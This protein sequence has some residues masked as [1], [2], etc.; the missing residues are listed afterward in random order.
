MPDGTSEWGG[1]PVAYS[2][3]DVVPRCRTALS[4]AI[5]SVSTHRG[6]SERLL[7]SGGGVWMDALLDDGTGVLLLRWLGRDSVPGVVKGAQ[8]VV[9]GTVSSS[10]DGLPLLLN[11]LYRFGGSKGSC[12]GD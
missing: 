3:A 6:T 12:L 7:Q 2:V 4:G 10:P 5:V 11:P 9:E 1:Q 8:L